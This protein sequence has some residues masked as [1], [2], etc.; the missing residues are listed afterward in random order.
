MNANENQ[1]PEV[2]VA[3]ES[4]LATIVK[5]EIDMQIA[6]AKAYPRSLTIFMNKVKSMA[7]VTPEVA[8]SCTYTLPRGDKKIE[9]PSVRLAEIVASSFGNIRAGARIIFNDGKTVTAQGIC[10]DLETNNMVTVEVKRSIL[11]HEWKNGA[12][13]GRMVT[14]SED[15][16]V[17][18]GNAA[19]AIAYRN[20]VFKVVPAALIEDAYEEVK[21]VARGTAETLV[22]RRD[23]AVK[24]FVDRGIKPEQ[25]CQTL[26]LKAITDI[27]LDKL[28][29]LS[30]MKS[31]FVNNES[32]LDELFLPVDD[33]KAKAK[34]ATEATAAKL[35]KT[36]NGAK[37]VATQIET[38]LGSQ[39]E[40][41][42]T[43]NPS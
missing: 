40:N 30:G 10:H 36:G 15:M 42:N 11:Q 19:C 31:A 25:I 21:R 20:A 38:G 3:Q 33:P 9:G 18:T 7:T 22:A 29:V 35:K 28:A 39:T 32:R 16:Q 1:T 14:M 4:A 12:K 2:I 34:K 5:A 27:D 8:E 24:F 43:E 13:T 37:D 6:T 23:K 26:G 17:V 41:T